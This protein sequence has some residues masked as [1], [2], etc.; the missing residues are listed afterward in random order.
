MQRSKKRW[1]QRIHPITASVLIGLAGFLLVYVIL[2]N[3]VSPKRHVLTVGEIAGS[4]ITATKEIEDE[5][6]TQ[7]RIDSARAQVESILKLDD[8]VTES[9]ISQVQENLQLTADYRKKY[10]EM[11]TLYKTPEMEVYL[12]PV[13]LCDEY[14]Q[15]LTVPNTI[16]R[17]QASS[18]L[19]V[20]ETRLISF[21]AALLQLVDEKMSAGVRDA[22]LQNAK[23]QILRDVQSVYYSVDAAYLP[24]AQ[25]LVEGCIT[26]NLFYDQEATE[27]ARQEAQDAVQP[28]IY[29]KGQNIVVKNEI[30]TQAQYE[31]VSKLGLLQD[32]SIDFNLYLGLAIVVLLV[33]VNIFVYLFLLERE[34]LTRPRMLLLIVTVYVLVMG[35]GVVTRQLS[36]Y[37]IPLQLGIFLMAILINRRLAIVCNASLAV[38]VG[39]LATGDEGL[40]ASG[41][42]NILLVA[43]ITGSIAVALSRSVNQRMSLVYTGLL[44]ALM[45]FAAMFGIGLMTMSSIRETLT[46]ALSF[47]G[48][49]VLSALLAMGFS[50]MLESV[51]AVVTPQKLMELADS[52]HPLLRKLQTEAPGTYQH[53]LIVAN[54]AE[55]AAQAIEADEL[56]ARVGAYYHDVG[57]LKRPYMFKENQFAAENPHDH[58]DPYV[59][60]AVITAHTR[61][62][63]LLAKKYKLPP[64]IENIIRQHHGQTT[65]AYFYYEACKRAE[66]AGTTVDIADF[67]YDGPK[68]DSKEAAI[69]FLADTMEAAV[70][71]MKKHTREDIENTVRKLIFTRLQDGQLENA[72]LTLAELEKITQAFVFA[73]SGFYHDRIEYPDVNQ[74]R[75]G[76]EKPELPPETPKEAGKPMER[77]ETAKEQ[78]T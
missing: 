17:D 19:M 38:L 78:T 74:V 12:P 65:A 64:C 61:D 40:L 42:F 62:G 11:I 8:T 70:R 59:S 29:K 20:G 22:E 55:A 47:A 57:K 5:V 76:A 2:F 56:L 77:Q 34:V 46:A 51:F 50:P 49:G 48:S 23:T 39:I 10:Q 26:E 60:A 63:V 1:F 52:N 54:L 68:P 36:I 13:S 9:V 33:F 18:I 37:L 41:M 24:L 71:S 27:Q 72:P 3:V 25:A 16:S 66:A 21:R 4:T 15:A 35:I 30:V 53:S 69:I 6:T 67:T 44:V 58:M 31:V 45:N 73:L 75:S 28:V 14:T 43:V 7:Q 32:D